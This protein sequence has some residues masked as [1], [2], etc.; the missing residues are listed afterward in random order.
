[1]T[2]IEMFCNAGYQ[3]IFLQFFPSVS[4]SGAHL[5]P[6]VSLS[7]CVLGD[8]PWRCLL[9]YSLSQVLGAY[10]ASAV[11]YTMYYGKTT[12][13]SESNQVSINYIKVKIAILK[14]A[15]NYWFVKA[16]QLTL[17]FFLKFAK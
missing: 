2:K 11:V 14:W 15:Q 5:N 13:M 10:L 7:F 17:G 9:P 8:L 3:H 4:H 1:M 12:G 6:A 16:T